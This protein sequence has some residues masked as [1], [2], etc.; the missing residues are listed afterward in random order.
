MLGV[1]RQVPLI[2]GLRDVLAR[3]PGSTAVRTR[4]AYALD[5]VATP[6]APTPRY[7][8]EREH[9]GA[10]QLSAQGAANPHV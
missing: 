6:I 4:V 2:D 9:L 8:G 1:T 5:V 3:T 10:D 7:P